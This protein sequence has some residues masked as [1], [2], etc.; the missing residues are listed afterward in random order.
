MKTLKTIIIISSI[1]LS[2]I[3]LSNELD[4]TKNQA[5]NTRRQGPP[6]EAYTACENKN[7][8]DTAQFVSP[9]GETRTG[10]CEQEGDRLVL[11]P[12][13]KPAQ[14]KRNA[15]GR[16]Q[17]PPP[18]A[19]TVCENKKSGDEAQFVSPHG[20]KI[21]GTCEKEGDQLVLRPYHPEKKSADQRRPKIDN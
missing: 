21:I 13:D 17:G 9:R 4:Q 7:A 15:G 3:V 6:P 16:N 18:E 5:S 1:F 20:E 12:D 19:Y 2:S 8:G 14:E 11:R 10:T